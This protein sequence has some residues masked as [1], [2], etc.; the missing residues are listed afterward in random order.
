MDD[1]SVEPKPDMQQE[2]ETLH[3]H[4]VEV[5]WRIH[6]LESI[7]GIIQGGLVPH[8]GEGRELNLQL[9]LKYYPDESVAVCPLF[10][11]AVL[12]VGNSKILLDIH[13]NSPGKFVA[14]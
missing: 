10:G 11:P 7:D 2:V 14:S 5:L 6:F 3:V 12:K 9:I 4:D 8:I 1:P 13:P